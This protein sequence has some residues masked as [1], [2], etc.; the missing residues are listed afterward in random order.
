[1]GRTTQAPV[2]LVSLKSCCVKK[3]IILR[4]C[5][6]VAK[7]TFFGWFDSVFE[8]FEPIRPL[9]LEEKSVFFFKRPARICDF[10]G[11]AGGVGL[12]SGDQNGRLPHISFKKN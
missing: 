12:P 1:M 9:Y 4:R 5:E 2:C 7:I 11:V 8:I 10:S 6:Y 3:E